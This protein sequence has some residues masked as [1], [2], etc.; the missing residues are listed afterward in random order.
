MSLFITLE[1]SKMHRILVI[2]ALALL[3]T[4]NNNDENG[5][6]TIDPFQNQDVAARNG[7]LVLLQ[8]DPTLTASASLSAKVSTVSTITS[9]HSDTFV[10]CPTSTTRIGI[11]SRCGLDGNITRQLFSSNN[12]ALT[13][14]DAIRDG[15]TR[16]VYAICYSSTLSDEIE[17]IKVA[18]T[19]ADTL[20]EATCSSG[21][22]LI[23]G[24]GA[25][26]LEG[27][28]TLSTSYPKD[29]STW[30]ASCDS[31]TASN[32]FVMAYCISESSP[33]VSGKTI[34]VRQTSF[35]SSGSQSNSQ[36]CNS[37][38]Q[39][40]NGGCAC[41]TA[42]EMDN[43]YTSDLSSWSCTCNGIDGSADNATA[44]A[45]CMQ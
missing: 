10:A 41:P 25:C 18:I 6:T 4:C 11:G 13:S 22:T 1:E 39:L 36:S 30:V 26:D 24:G 7:D 3:I 29:N 15:E 5:E 34:T 21:K 28:R 17:E 14:C 38:E 9:S 8:S 16:K 35:G 27:S 23:A 44:Y 40:L 31:I 32:A 20:T 43:S 33:L 2:L 12:D 19:A 42:T 37:G 45:M